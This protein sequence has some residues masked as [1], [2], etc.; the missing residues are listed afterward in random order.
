[1]GWSRA[2]QKKF[3]A[4][5]SAIRTRIFSRT[6]SSARVGLIQ[7]L[8]Q[9]TAIALHEV[10]SPGLPVFNREGVFV[11]L[12]S[13]SFGQSFVQFSRPDRGGLPVVLINVE[14]SSVFQLADEVLPYVKRIPADV[15]GRP[16]AWLG[17]YGIEPVDPEVA[18]YLKLETQGAAVLSEVLEGS[19]AEKAGLKDRDVLV[20]LEGKPL[21]RL[22]PDRVVVN[23]IEREI[24]RRQ[25]GDT[26]TFSVLRGDQR[27]EI[28]TVLGDEPR[29]I[30]EADK[31]YFD[32]LGFT[33]REFVYGD[34]I[35]RRHPHR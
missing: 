23:Y 17:A 27:L 28:K 32:R 11:G 21:P 31:K 34:A 10:A 26:I 35:A 33:V 3:G 14:E 9:K 5:V 13:S 16:L 1:M 22:K 18:K 24:A 20:A 15:N 19:P 7:S 29:L 30:R 8:P 25:L 6:S 2:W 4:S 12:A